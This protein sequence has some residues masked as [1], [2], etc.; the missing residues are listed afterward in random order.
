LGRFRRE[1]HRL[2]QGRA[3]LARAGARVAQES[4][5]RPNGFPVHERAKP[6]IPLA[7]ISRFL[8]VLVLGGL[9]P[10]VVLLAR[11]SL[12]ADTSS[13]PKFDS[14]YVHLISTV[15]PEDAFPRLARG[16]RPFGKT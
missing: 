6:C 12:N 1:T 8:K 2:R 5:A 9:C 14:R 10:G 7:T 4:K 11:A 13:Q 15:K 16:E 3:I